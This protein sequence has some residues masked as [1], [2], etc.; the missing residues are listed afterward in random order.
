ML[1]LAEGDNNLQRVMETQPNPQTPEFAQ[2][3]QQ[4]S[5]AMKTFA[6]PL[7]SL[8]VTELIDHLAVLLQQEE[9]PERK[10]VDSIKSIFFKKKEAAAA[11]H[12]E[13]V[14]MLEIQE[15]RLNDLL[16]TFK[17]KDR[18][19]VEEQELL[20]QRALETKR[21]LLAQLE[22]LLESNEDFANIYKRYHE[23]RDEWK[24]AGEVP[25]Q[26]ASEIGK[27]FTAVQDRFYDLKNINEQLREYDFKKNLEGK[28]ELLDKIAPLIEHPDPIQ[29]LRQMQD[30]LKQ[31]EHLGP[32]A[33]ELRAEIHSAYKEVTTKIYK[34]HQDFFDQKKAQEQDNLQ[35]KEAICVE[36]EQFL[37]ELLS[38]ELTAKQWESFTT[39]IQELQQSWRG[40]GYASKRD[41]DV[42]YKRFRAAV[43]EFFSRKSEFFSHLRGEQQEKIRLKRELIERANALKESTDWERTTAEL[44]ELQRQ[45]TEIGSVPSKMSRKLWEEFRVP[46]DYFF[47][48]KKAQGGGGRRQA[49]LENLAAKRAII[50]KLHQLAEQA[51]IN[52]VRKEVGQLAKNWQAIGFVPYAEK[53]KIFSEYKQLMDELYGR[54]RS[55]RSQRRLDG[56][57]A[58]LKNLSGKG[59]ALSEER[60]RMQRLLDKMMQELNN[61][62]RNI[63]CL[64]VSSK[65]GSGL[66]R[67]IERKRE[68]LEEDIA[69]LKE[70]IALIKD[71]ENKG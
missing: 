48:R 27:A 23:L 26:Q 33:K 36:V 57:N 35:A 22:A 2:Q 59:G 32:V 34:R 31:W 62:E 12:P 67:E 5:A 63:N 42:V 25:A 70:K 69:L 41:N 1:A 68:K 19:R 4:E 16:M 51:D 58:T 47:E 20:Q 71:K 39:R 50:D 9:L 10:S 38:G 61:Y 65:S 15:T 43:D 3:A 18:R 29:A 40:I 7:L 28:R 52:L 64:N 8:S 11:Q 44:K 37:G 13:Q 49:E 46:F 56:Y 60:A 17:E 55:D 66:L 54:V 30:Y 14:E 6:N 53:E 21:G 24:G 45:W